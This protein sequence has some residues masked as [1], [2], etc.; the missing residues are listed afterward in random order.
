MRHIIMIA[1]GAALALGAGSSAFADQ[2]TQTLQCADP[3]FPECHFNPQRSEWK[4][5]QRGAT[6]C[7]AA[8]QSYTCP[9]GQ[10][11]NGDGSQTPYC[12]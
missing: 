10:Q 3:G 2:C 4:C 7:A 6:F 8:A 12:R 11:C 5:T 9:Q 1:A